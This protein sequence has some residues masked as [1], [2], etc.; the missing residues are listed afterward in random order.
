MH[1]AELLSLRAVPAAGVSLALTR[2][3]PLSCAHC[4]TNS[5]LTSEEAPA[6]MFVR[7]V[8]SFGAE[9]HPE[10]LSIS[11][12]EAF[13]RPALVAELAIRARAVGCRTVALS[14]MFFARARRIP[15]RIHRA[16]DE[17]D[18]FSASLDVFHEREVRRADVFRVLDELLAEGKD[19]SIHLVGLDADDPYLVSTTEEVRRAFDDRVPLLVNS[20][21]A[22]GRAAEWLDKA[23]PEAPSTLTAEPCTLAA[24]PVV[25][26]D[27]TIVACGN[28]DVVDGPAP[29]HLRLGHADTDSWGE[30]RARC[31]RSHMLHALRSFGPEFIAG[32]YGSGPITCNGYCSTCQQ[33]SS[34]EPLL[35]RVD[36]MAPALA[37][38][39]R[40]ITSLQQESGPAAF[41]GRYGLARYA[42]LVTLGAPA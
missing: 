9:D 12:G 22:T 10:V 31:L 29:A 17:L 4:A 15:P 14:G 41:I 6:D 35:R 32:K 33:L 40:Q 25:A 26:F 20:V 3:C 24:W 28:D 18:H 37:V 2:K 7:F 13:L 38:L 16:I 8:E 19:V 21:N 1:L 39:E 42:D 5:T 11:G 30:V 36:E 23:V 34:D 27:G